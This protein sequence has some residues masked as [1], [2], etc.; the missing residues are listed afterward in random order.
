MRVVCTAYRKTRLCSG[1]IR[2][3]KS[4]HLYHLLSFI[5]FYVDQDKDRDTKL[6]NVEN[7]TSIKYKKTVQK[8]IFGK[9]VL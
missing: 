2:T 1:L 5:V 7:Y 6:L 8:V 3:E 9:I 4:K